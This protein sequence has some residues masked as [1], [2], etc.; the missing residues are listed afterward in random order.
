MYIRKN[1]KDRLVFDSFPWLQGL[2]MVLLLGLIVFGIFNGLWADRMWQ[3]TFLAVFGAVTLITLV[4]AIQWVQ[5]VFD[6]SAGALEV[7]RRGLR[8]RKTARYPLSALRS[9]ELESQIDRWGGEDH[10]YRAVLRVD[11]ESEPVPMTSIY[12]N[13]PHAAQRSIGVAQR[14]LKAGHGTA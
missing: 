10:S 5:V 6:R 4:W 3:V 2:A 7:H 13:T 11:G 9:V 8:G 1:T 12:R 14:W